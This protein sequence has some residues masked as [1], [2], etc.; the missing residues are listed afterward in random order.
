[1]KIPVLVDPQENDYA[2]N[3]D[4]QLALDNG[5]N[6]D[7]NYES[8]Y[9]KLNGSS[10]TEEITTTENTTV[11]VNDEE[12]NESE[13][14]EERI[15]SA[16][17]IPEGYVSVDY[18]VKKDD[19][20]LGIADR[21]NS[22]VSDIRNWNNIPYTTTIRVGQ[23]LK[24]YVPEENQEYFTSIDKTSKIEEKAIIESEITYHKIRRGE[25]LGLIAS[26]YGVKISEIKEWN[27]LR[28]NKIIAGK[29]LKLYTGGKTPPPTKTSYVTTNK[30]YKNTKATLNRYKVLR[31]DAISKI[32]EMYGVT[33][34]DI[35]RWNGLKSNRIIAGQT[36]KIFTSSPIAE[37]NEK[38]SS[39]PNSNVNYY[40][41]KSGDTIGE[42]A[43]LYNVRASDIRKWN[44]IYG[45]KIVAG[46][47]L[48]I[49]S[50]S[51]TGRNDITTTKTSS[52]SYSTYT[53]KKGDNLGAIAEQYGVT[54][55]D[56]RKWNGISGSKIIAGDKL[57]IY[58]KTT[59]QKD[60]TT[61]KNVKSD[62]YS[63]HRVKRGETIS[64][65][66]E[67]YKVSISSIRS[68]NKLTS[69]KIIAGK[70][71]K[72]KN[73][74]EILTGDKNNYHLVT[75]GESLY[76]IAKKYNTTIQKIKSL[77]NLSGSKIKAGQKLK[78]G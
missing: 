58:T 5:N 61:T 17:V 1:L 43:E 3:T 13:T 19:S 32:A 41:I 10:T 33:T 47:T 54:A 53:I 52:G 30:V 66:A 39:T 28:G 44:G 26:R 11:A 63:Y 14:I 50:D 72:I 34:R 2:F 73:G 4:T 67:K 38:N 56:I 9:T 18:S 24:I 68:W 23:K 31:G 15:N 36:L 40:K 59:T 62:N 45:N 70:T 74:S 69:N 60:F 76:T 65:I 42:I 78:V 64:Q 46:K 55:S 35:R 20:L 49:Y 8:P 27:H 25:S 71:L 16:P 29:K 57:K 48:K 6:S 75:R 12:T 37:E 22:R 21:F 77:N 51:Y 7:E